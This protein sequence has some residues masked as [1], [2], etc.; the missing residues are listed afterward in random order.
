MSNDNLKKDKFAGIF[1]FS[2]LHKDLGIPEKEDM[3]RPE[4]KELRERG[5]ITPEEWEDIRANSWEFEHL[6]PALT[7]QALVNV[8]RHQLKNAQPKRGSGPCIT[9]DESLIHNMIPLLCERLAQRHG[10]LRKAKYTI[11]LA[12]TYLNEYEN[13]ADK[14]THAKRA[15]HNEILSWREND[16]SS[17]NP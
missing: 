7:D 14:A 3:I 8:V 12:M 15:L 10:E 11:S 9:Y 4:Y 16:E 2:K 6:Y 17:N 1:D 5:N 13:D